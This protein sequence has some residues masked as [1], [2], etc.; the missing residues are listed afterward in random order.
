MKNLVIA[1]L[2]AL[3][4]MMSSAFPSFANGSDATTL[5]IIPTG[6]L[7]GGSVGTYKLHGADIYVVYI[8]DLSATATH[9]NTLDNYSYSVFPATNMVVKITNR[10]DGTPDIIGN[11]YSGGPRINNYFSGSTHDNYNFGNG[12]FWVTDVINSTI[13][14]SSFGIDFGSQNFFEGEEPVT[15]LTFFNALIGTVLTP[16]TYRA[17]LWA[18]TDDVYIIENKSIKIISAWAPGLDNGKKKG[19]TPDG[20]DKGNKIGW[21]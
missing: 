21:E 8:M 7:N 10:P 3:T 5:K 4:L 11:T 19:K 20:F 18:G 2:I 14:V 6:Q 9:W 12:G 13:M 17:Y 16:S 15:D 1:V